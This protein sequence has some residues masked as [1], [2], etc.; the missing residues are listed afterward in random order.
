MMNNVRTILVT[1]ASGGF[2]LLTVK[3]LVRRG[4]RVFACFRDPQG[5]DASVVDSLAR[6]AR[7]TDG[8]FEAVAMDIT[9]DDSVEEAA[10]FVRSRTERLDVAVNNAGISAMGLNE[11]FTSAQAL[12]LFDVNALGAH[13]VNRA[14]LPLMK[15]HRSGLLVHVSTGLARMTMPCFGL[16]SASKAAMEAI[17]ESYRYELS[18]LGIDS[19]ILEPSPYPTNLGASALT[20]GDPARLREYGELAQLPKR[21]MDGLTAMFAGPNAPNPQDVP[22]AILRLIETPRGERP[23]RTLVGSGGEALMELNTLTDRIQAALFAA[24]GMAAM[25]RVAR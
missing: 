3:T 16:Y 25:L 17:A 21:M 14:I 18:G 20:A 7:E 15:P 19:V 12:A 22:D 6:T 8:V 5:K 1:G 9:R 23:L 10:A 13:R 11:G 24:Q 2:G 4:F